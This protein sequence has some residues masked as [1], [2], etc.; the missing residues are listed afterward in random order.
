LHRD[1]RRLGWFASSIVRRFGV[2]P[3]RPDRNGCQECDDDDDGSYSACLFRRERSIGDLFTANVVSVH[4]IE[5]VVVIGT[6]IKVA[7]LD[8]SAVKVAV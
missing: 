6:D 8:V 2:T 5:P 7:S 1:S 4:P 3:R